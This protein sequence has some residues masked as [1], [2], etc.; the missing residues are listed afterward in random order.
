[1]GSILFWDAA[2]QRPYD[3]RTRHEQALGGTEAMVSRVADALGAFVVQ[4]NRVTP[5]G[6]YLPPGKVD[7]VDAV[8]VVRDPAAIAGVR[9]LYPD[10]RLFLWLHDQ[11]QPWS[12]RGRALVAHRQ[13]LEAGR[14]TV[15]CV[16]DHQR[17]G[18]EATLRRIGPEMAARAL[19]I[20][21]AVDDALQPDATPVDPDRLLFFSS[22][23][24]GL[25]YSLDAFA[26]IRRRWPDM[27]LDLANPGYKA[28][29]TVRAPGVRVLGAL[30]PEQLQ[31]HVRGA[32]CTLCLNFVLPETFGLVLAESLAMGTPVLAYDCGAAMEVVGDT[33]QVLPVP[34]GARGYQRMACALGPRLRPMLA[35]A[36]DRL[37]L[38]DECIERIGDWRAGRQSRPTLDPQFRLTPVVARWRTLLSGVDDAQ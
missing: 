6:R 11:M 20:H 35:P 5:N 26:A 12:K 24:K 27:Q 3:A 9:A 38:F 32:L 16:S 33:R 1:M 17:G 29:A 36:A 4:H 31:A 19:T 10:A 22:P 2:C 34:A 28:A 15:V 30:A 21:N 23:N 13:A 18:V 37:G 7:G 14:T 25:A 8:V